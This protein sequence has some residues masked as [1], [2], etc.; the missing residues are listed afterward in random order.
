MSWLRNLFGDGDG[1]TP[2]EPIRVELP[3]ATGEVEVRGD[4]PPRKTWAEG[5]LRTEGIPINPHLPMIE[6]EAEV[7]LRSPRVVAN[8]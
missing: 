5:V 1:K 2:V 4:Q 8:L 3:P 6:S 7:T